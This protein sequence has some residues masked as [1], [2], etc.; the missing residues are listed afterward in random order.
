MTTQLDMLVI[1]S[2][3]RVS[4]TSNNFKINLDENVN[5]TYE[6]VSVSILN[7]LYN[8][9]ANQNDKVYITHSVDGA[10]TLTLTAGYYTGSTLATELKTQLD[11]I[12]AVVYT[13][14][15]SSTTGKFTITAGS[16][17][18]NFTFATNTSN[19][20]RYILGF[21]EEDGT[22]ATS[23]VSDNVANLRLTDIIAVKISQDN[24]TNVTLPGGVEA[25]FVVPI[26][27]ESFGDIINPTQ[28][29]YFS[30]LLRFTSQISSLDIEL[31]NSTGASLSINGVEWSFVIKKLF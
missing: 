1:E 16:G 8:V 2:K 17:N 5:G 31:L 6:V 14:T 13:V 10:Q 29:S 3:S 9:V 11:S 15:Y 7:S 4:G 20:A 28:N 26:Q 30:Q 24:N 23:L 22:P 12:S 27:N 19:T 18:I 25:S 21:D